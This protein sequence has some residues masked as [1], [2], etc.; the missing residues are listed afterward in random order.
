M[1]FHDNIMAFFSSL[2]TLTYPASQNLLDHP[3]TPRVII[4]TLK[5][6]C[7]GYEPTGIKPSKVKNRSS[8]LR[9]NR[10]VSRFYRLRMSKTYV[11]WRVQL[12]QNVA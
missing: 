6:I 10:T 5:N 9:L 2:H 3:P 12:T 1:Y 7:S 11:F 4:S 8:I